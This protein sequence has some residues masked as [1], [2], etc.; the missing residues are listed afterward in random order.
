MQAFTAV[1]RKRHQ[2]KVLIAHDVAQ[3]ACGIHYQQCFLKTGNKPGKILKIGAMLFVGIDSQMRKTTFLHRL[4]D[5]T[6]PSFHGVVRKDGISNI[7]V[8][9][10]RRY[11]LQVIARDR[12]HGVIPY[13]AGKRS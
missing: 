13:A 10:R 1:T 7:R 4:Q 9:L 6:Q 2:L 3:R 11:C 5:I 8:G 12:C